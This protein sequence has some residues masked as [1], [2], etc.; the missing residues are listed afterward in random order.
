MP[1][2]YRRLLSFVILIC[3]SIELDAYAQNLWFETPAKRECLPDGSRKWAA[4]IT[5]SGYHGD[6]VQAC[7]VTRA[8]IGGTDY[9]SENC[10]WNGARVWGEFRV[11]DDSCVSRTWF[12]DPQRKQCEGLTGTRRWAA[13]ITGQNYKG[14]WVAACKNTSVTI[15]GSVVRALPGTC[16]WSGGRVWGEFS[17]RG[18]DCP[19]AE[20]GVATCDLESARK[21]CAVESCR[22]VSQSG[23]F[24][25]AQCLPSFQ[26]ELCNCSCRAGSSGAAPKCTR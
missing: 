2:L 26:P 14:D 17:T 15:G 11:A 21:G 9:P 23:T 6:W 5:G 1:M 24:Q 10:G 12:Q 3:V 20:S 4:I 7:R 22:L 19:F 25:Y 18:D 8:P 16:A 13:I